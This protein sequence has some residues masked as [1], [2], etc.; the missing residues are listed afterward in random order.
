MGSV[1]LPNV[2]DGGVTPAPNRLYVPR[3][4]APNVSELPAHVLGEVIKL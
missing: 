2:A 1:Y 4:P 3:D